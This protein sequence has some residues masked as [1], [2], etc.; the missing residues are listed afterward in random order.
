MSMDYDKDDMM[1]GALKRLAKM[2]AE[3]KMSK[4]SKIGKRMDKLE[5][6][7]APRKPF[8]TKTTKKPA[9]FETMKSSKKPAFF[10]TMKSSKRGK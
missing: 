6:E 9:F 5:M 8:I 7:Q 3:N 2:K 4:A 10:E 1:P